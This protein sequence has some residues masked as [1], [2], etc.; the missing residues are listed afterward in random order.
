[1]IRKIYQSY[2]RLLPAFWVRL[3]SLIWMHWNTCTTLCK[4]KGLSND[5]IDTVATILYEVLS[6]T[7]LDPVDV[8]KIADSFTEMREDYDQSE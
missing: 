5:H 8:E 2:R 1:M 7:K 3:S 6:E 4:K